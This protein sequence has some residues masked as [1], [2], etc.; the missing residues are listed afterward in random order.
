[1][2]MNKVR[3]SRQPMIYVLD[4]VKDRNGTIVADKVG[5]DNSSGHIVVIAEESGDIAILIAVGDNHSGEILDKPINVKWNNATLT[6]KIVV[7]EY[8][9]TYGGPDV[10]MKM[11]NEGVHMMID[12]EVQD[13]L[14]LDYGYDIIH[15][16]N[17]I[18]YNTLVDIDLWNN[19]RLVRF[20]ADPHKLPDTEVAHE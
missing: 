20:L 14:V 18:D 13:A 6:A 19:E 12:D 4:V 17:D 8:S 10:E 9:S 2:N 15:M 11:D 3:M 16:I 1:M 5:G 7:N